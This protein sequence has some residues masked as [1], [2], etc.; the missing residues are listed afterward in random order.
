[1]K[2]LLR[3]IALLLVLSCLFAPATLADST[4]DLH[5]SIRG[6]LSNAMKDHYY[7]KIEGNESGYVIR[8]ADEGIAAAVLS[9]AIGLSPREDWQAY[10]NSIINWA[11]SISNF[12]KECG[13]ENPNLLFILVDD[14]QMEE[15]LLAIYNGTVI[16]D[17]APAK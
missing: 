6:L 16:F 17:Y 2:K 1:M 15:T 4:T 8:I 11:N 13:V 7:Y 9:T 10:S 3:R 12:I 14:W 5:S